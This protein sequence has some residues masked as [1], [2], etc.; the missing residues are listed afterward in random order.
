MGTTD[1]VGLVFFPHALVRYPLDP[2]LPRFVSPP[3]TC[4]SLSRP[5]ADTI[6]SS[7]RVY[8]YPIRRKSRCRLHIANRTRL[9]VDA[10][11]RQ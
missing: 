7:R 5:Y 6:V 3:S 2:D 4:P 8:F 9:G 10:E 1:H 11:R